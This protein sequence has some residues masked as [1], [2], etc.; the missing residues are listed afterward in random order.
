MGFKCGWVSTRRVSERKPPG[1]NTM[2]SQR[3]QPGARS[4]G[5]CHANALLTLNALNATAAPQPVS[6]TSASAGSAPAAARSVSSDAAVPPPSSSRDSAVS[7]VSAA[8]S[9]ASGSPWHP[10]TTS[11]ASAGSA[12]AEIAVSEVVVI[13]SAVSDLQRSA[14]RWNSQKLMSRDSSVGWAN[15]VSPWCIWCVRHM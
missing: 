5:H 6:A 9:D 8:R 3:L 11:D 7:C 14:T 2:L 13:W 1:I 10:V 15:T 4:R 12:A